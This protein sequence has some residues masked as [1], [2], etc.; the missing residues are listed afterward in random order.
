LRGYE[1]AL[2]LEAEGYKNVTVLEGGVMAWPY[3]RE[4]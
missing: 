3:R 1:A 2:V 4:K